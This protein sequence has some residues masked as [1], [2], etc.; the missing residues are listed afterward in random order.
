MAKWLIPHLLLSLWLLLLLTAL[1][2]AAQQ[3]NPFELKHR[4]QLDTT[5]NSKAPNPFEVNRPAA[6]GEE[7]VPNP[8]ESPAAVE[9]PAPASTELEPEEQPSIE[10]SNPFDLKSS[11]P[12]AVIEE[13]NP[14]DI[15]RPKPAVAEQQ[16]EAAAPVEPEQPTR[17]TSFLFWTILIMLII[18]TLSVS[19][20]RSFIVRSYR[21]FTNENFLK[22][23]HR[24]QGSIVKAPYLI[25]YVSF[26]FNTAVFVYLVG[27]HFESIGPDSFGLLFQLFG[28][29]TAIFLTKHIV[30]KIIGATFPVNKELKLYSF[31][32]V[33]FSI[34]I[35]L[36][37][38]PL[39]TLIAF[40]PTGMTP[41]LVFGT[42]LLVFLI[43]LFRTFRGLFI[44]GRFITF[45]KF[46]FF[47][48][49]CTVEIAPL[50]ILI[51]VI[52]LKTGIQ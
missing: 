9:A 7:E 17:S 2:A 39:N 33:I 35:G 22:L 21:A 43:Y 47:M 11:A 40:A 3:G 14:F 23:I 37:L 49:L 1:P 36:L 15:K 24:D 6:G 46:H 52:T 13:G 16:A 12:P 19:M 10:A 26:F 42:L 27:R 38:A 29:V 31:T 20:Y 41:Y 50:L 34:I 45:Q 28:L 30:L 32:I 8:A 25:L 51:K 44:A 5:A 18:L 4:Q 48:Y